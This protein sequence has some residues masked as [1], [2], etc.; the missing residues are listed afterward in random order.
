MLDREKICCLLNPVLTSPDAL[1]SD[2]ST[3]VTTE[4]PITDAI[5]HLRMS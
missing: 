1:Y 3:L 4:H 2:Q 5:D